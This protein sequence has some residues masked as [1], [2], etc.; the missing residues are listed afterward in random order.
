MSL[1]EITRDT[2]EGVVTE[3]V[4]FH[5]G[6]PQEVDIADMEEPL[7][8]LLEQLSEHSRVLEHDIMYRGMQIREMLLRQAR[9]DGIVLRLVTQTVASDLDQMVQHF[10]RDH[11]IEGG[12]RLLLENPQLLALRHYGRNAVLVTYEAYRRSNDY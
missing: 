5:R 1:P 3:S 6:Q 12:K 11:A 7:K 2:F 10:S 9:K 8:S 4:A